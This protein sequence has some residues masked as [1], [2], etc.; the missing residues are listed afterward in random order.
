MAEKNPELTSSHRHT[1]L[2]ATFVQQTLEMTQ[3]PNRLEGVLRPSTVNR[4]DEATLKRV[5][6]EKQL[7][8]KPQVR[9]H[10]LREQRVRPHIGTLGTGDLL[11]EDPPRPATHLHADINSVTTQSFHNIRIQLRI[12]FGSVSRTWTQSQQMM[13]RVASQSQ[14]LDPVTD[15]PIVILCDPLKIVVMLCFKDFLCSLIDS[16]SASVLLT[17]G[18]HDFSVGFA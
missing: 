3:R 13:F 16:F 4:G 12:T 17:S 1:E 2:T 11:W 9:D 5:A 8:T 15:Q 18:F 10:K 6:G 14:R 7:G